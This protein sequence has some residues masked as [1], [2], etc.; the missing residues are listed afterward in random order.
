MDRTSSTSTHQDLP[1]RVGKSLSPT[2]IRRRQRAH[3]L[4]ICVQHHVSGGVIRSHGEL[5]AR[6][7]RRGVRGGDY[8]L[9]QKYASLALATKIVRNVL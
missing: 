3:T 9:K 4:W 1:G 5:W 2:S 8:F 6:G 7:E